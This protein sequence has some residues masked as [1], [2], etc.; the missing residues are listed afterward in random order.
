MQRHLRLAASLATFFA[1]LSITTAQA[2][3][4][5]STNHFVGIDSG[6]VANQNRSPALRGMADVVWSTV[7]SVP[8]AAWLRLTY[9]GVLLSGSR[10]PGSNG[11]FLRLTSLLDGQRQTQH[12]VHID[13]W[14]DTSAY[15]N[16]DSVLVELLAQPGTGDNR[17]MIGDVIAGPILP[18]M[19]DTICGSVDDRVLSNDQRLARVLPVGC[20]VWLI[21]DCNHCFLT[22]GHCGGGLQTVQF[23]VP[24]STSSGAIQNPGPQDQYAVDP[25]SLQGNGGQGTG[26]DFAYFGVFPNSTTG[27]LPFQANGGQAFDLLPA[28]PPVMGQTIRVTGNGSTTAPVSPT[29]YLVQKTHTGPYSST[30]GTTIQY[31]VDTTGGNSGSPVFIDGTNQAIGIHT[32]GGCTAT[33]GANNGTASQHPGLQAALANPIGVCACP[34]L[35][36]TYV[37]GLPTVVA[38]N[39]TSTIRVQ[40]GG[41]VPLLAGSVRFHVSTGGAFQTLIPTAVNA[42]TFDASVPATFCGSLVSFYFSA[43]DTNV[44]THTDPANAPASVHTAVAA[45]GLTTLRNYNFN[46]A[47]PGWTVINTALTTGAWVRGTPIDPRGPASDFDGS[48]QCWVTGNVANEDVDGGPTRLLTEVVSLGAALD[49]VVHYAL[50]FANDDNDDRLVVEASNDGGVNWV[51]V[52]D[53]GPF[54]GWVAHQMRVRD[55]FATPNLFV[56]RYSVADNPNNS[57]TEAAL[58]AFRIDDIQCTAPTWMS[59]G[60]GCTNGPSAPVLQLVSLPAIGGTF[61]LAVQNVGPGFPFMLTGLSQLNLP[62]LLPEF[63]TGCTL[64]ASPDLAQLLVPVAGTA[65]WSFNIPNTPTLAGERLYNQAFEFGGLW[66]LSNGGVGEVR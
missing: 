54:T 25:S 35:T 58:D 51:V 66:T 56:L 41:T 43:Q 31:A 2:E 5:Q 18:A 24:L 21:N 65:Q 46:T 33:G 4:A 45:N 47:P 8:N 48:G 1:F 27:L 40:I 6:L 64:L 39:G 13:Q 52:S 32:H 50:W 61:A 49:P 9:A 15:F 23:N 19:P 30:F 29:W 28:A 59:Y 55:Y 10:E 3:P 11:S 53:L 17:L 42:N 57:V 60:S 37:P 62:L 44:T 38:P 26:N 16:G 20:T 14:Q 63:A 36:F 12:L 7:V 34:G 22:A